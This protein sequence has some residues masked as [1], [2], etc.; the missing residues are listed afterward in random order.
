M[1]SVPFKRCDKN[2]KFGGDGEG[3]SGWMCQIPVNL[4]GS[5]GRIQCFVIFGATPILLGRPIL[6]FLQAVVDFGGR[7]MK[8]MGGDWQEIKKGKHDSMLLRLAEN[9]T[10]GD[11]LLNPIFDL[12]SEDDD[13]DE[14]ETFETY[15][16]D[17][18]ADNR[19]TELG[20]WVATCM[21]QP[22]ETTL[23]ATGQ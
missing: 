21:Q 8:L 17:M 12:V 19:Y 10:N 5:V 4:G 9:V 7:R 1:H 13:H 15:L 14:L 16:N 6:E 18:K 20:Q 23:V 3:H 22:P 2:F 11:Q